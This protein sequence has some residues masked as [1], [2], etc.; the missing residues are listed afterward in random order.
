MYE[1]DNNSQT[2]QSVNLYFGK[3]DA[4][5]CRWVHS[6][7]R[8]LFSYL[9]REAIK[10][11]LN[12]DTNYHLPTFETKKSINASITK[13]LSISCD[14]PEDKQVYDFVTSFDDNMRS[15]E[16]KKILR[17]YLASSTESSADKLNNIAPSKTSKPESTSK[18]KDSI[19][20]PVTEK[21]DDRIIKF[22]E[23]SKNRSRA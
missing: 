6:V 9:V 3:K 18:P 17:K 5:L 7:P 13:P 20:K 2:L 4:D 21:K 22:I 15:Y 8:G 16:V 23:S 10:S 1:K 12:G 11:H 19:K 14:T